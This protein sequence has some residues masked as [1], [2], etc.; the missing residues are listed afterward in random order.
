MEEATKR[1]AGRF[2]SFLAPLFPGYLFLSAADGAPPA[3]V[4][5][6]T[7][8]VSRLVSFSEGSPA[9]V[10]R[11][12]VSG[13]MARC[14]DQGVLKPMDVLAPGDEVRITS[15]PFADFVGK[16]EAIGAQQRIWVLLDLLGGA[17]KVAMRQKNVQR[18]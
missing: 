15:G 1:Q 9:E 2:V 5:N 14:D 16:V 6:S 17:A 3:R 8:G 4:V 12:I 7:Y 18:T 10:P 11:E 13:L